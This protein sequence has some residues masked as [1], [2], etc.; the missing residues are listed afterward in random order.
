[1]RLHL[2]TN[3]STGSS[4]NQCQNV[5]HPVYVIWFSQLDCPCLSYLLLLKKNAD[6]NL[7]KLLISLLPSRLVMGLCSGNF[8]GVIPGQ[9]KT[10]P[11]FQ[12][13]EAFSCSLL[14]LFF[15]PPPFLYFIFFFVFSF[16]RLGDLTRCVCPSRWKR[17]RVQ[18]AQ[19]MTLLKAG[20][21][22]RTIGTC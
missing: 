15:F 5:H 14:S 7:P 22:G 8:H 4:C 20:T 13:W 6:S 21:E 17:I 10:T 3:M 9:T 16:F 11:A 1:M 2:I 12:A 19:N 18:S